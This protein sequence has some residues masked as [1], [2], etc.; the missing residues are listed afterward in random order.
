MINFQWRKWNKTLHRDIGY[1]SVAMVI[2][3]GVSG[4][5]VNHI[6]DWNPNY[7]LSKRIVQINPIVSQDR[8]EIIGQTVS[9]LSIMESPENYFRPDSNTAQLFYPGKTYSVDLPTGNVLI[10]S[11]PSRPVLFEMNQLHLNAVKGVWTYIADIFAL[12]LIFMGISGMF[13]LKGST[14]IMGR[15]KWFVVI[16]TIIPLFYWIWYQYLQ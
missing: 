7:K 3:Y 1:L 13:I 14:G 16:G 5:A 4:I 11:T 10:E 2:I 8:D 6:G 12:G 15:G 9:S